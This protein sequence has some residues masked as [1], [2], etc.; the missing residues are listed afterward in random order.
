MKIFAVNGSPHKRKG[1][2]EKI[3][4]P[5]LEG[6]AAA[7]AD[8]DL[9]YLQEKEIKPC[10]GCNAC[11]LKTPG[12][13]AQR[14]DMSAL[15]DLMRSCEVAVLASPIYVGGVTGQM[16]TFL[17]RLTPV[18]KPFLE[19][20]DGFSVHEKPEGSNF[21]GIVLVSNNGFHELYHFDDLVS[22][23]RSIARMMHAELLGALLRPHGVV[24][25]MAEKHMP[26]KVAAVYDA[27]RQAG[28][29]LV[30]Q[31]RVSADLEAEVARELVPRDTF[32]KVM[33]DY[34]HKAWDSAG[35]HDSD[36]VPH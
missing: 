20:V 11:W 15:I 27:A 33:N 21:K 34:F 30:E 13:G 26:A 9:I 22:H 29:Q 14:D 35:G 36:R 12:R 17:D 25:E 3:L 8:I 16:K 2:T 6:A 4:Q 1:N 23:M 10:L 28:R 24:L 18:S 7:G 31:G 32:I 5:F 19:V